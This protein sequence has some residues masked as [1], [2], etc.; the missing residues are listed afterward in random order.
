MKRIVCF[1][2][3]NT[4]GYK[5]L[6]GERYSEE[7]RWPCLLQKLLGDGY[8]IEE[9]GL[10]G[11]TTAFDDPVEEYRNGADYI[12]C[13]LDT[14]APVD[15]VIIMLGT[16]DLK[17][18]LG[19]TAF[20]IARGIERLI[21]KVQ[22]SD[23]GR[24]GKQPGILLVSPVEVGENISECEA[25][26]YF[27]T[28]S[29]ESSRE[30]KMHYAKLASDYNCDFLSASDYAKPCKEDAVHL[31]IAGHRALADAIYSKLKVIYKD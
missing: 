13:C 7:E 27:D 17:R 29:V 23:S 11:R 2:D 8:K 28:S 30:L 10:N 12:E 20:F 9:E 4:W 16:N 14:N 22:K 25:Y 5:A 21:K 18:H 19:N 26:Y 1:G 31:D 24:N 6:T 15:L 3:S